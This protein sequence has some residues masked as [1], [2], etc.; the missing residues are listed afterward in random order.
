MNKLFRLLTLSCLY[1]LL[2][3][4]SLEIISSAPDDF[5]NIWKIMGILLY[6][7]I[8][9]NI[10]LL[11]VFSKISIKKQN[12]FTFIMSFLLLYFLSN[13]YFFS[14]D[15]GLM[16]YFVFHNK[17]IFDTSSLA[18][19]QDIFIAITL[20]LFTVLIFKFFNKKTIETMIIFILLV[21]MASSIKFIYLINTNKKAVIIKD[22]KTIKHKGVYDLK[23]EITFSKNSQNVLII[24]FDRFM[25]GFMP[26][27]LKDNP[28]LKQ[29]LSG[30]VW[31]PN[32]LSLGIGTA[33]GLAPIYGGYKFADAKSMMEDNF[34]WN[35]AHQIDSTNNMKQRYELST[36]FLL[37][38]FYDKGYE[39]TIFDANYLSNSQLNSM[40]NNTFKFKNIRDNKEYLEV[41]YYPYELDTK[42]NTKSPFSMTKEYMIP[43]SLF[44]VVSPTLRK[45]IYN[46]GTWLASLSS[47]AMNYSG[48]IREI[49]YARAWRHISEIKDDTDGSFNFI[50]SNLTHNVP[51][52]RNMNNTFQGIIPK[53]S[54][55]DKKRFK[56]KHTASHY[57]IALEALKQ[58]SLWFKWLKD[59]D[60]YDNTKI[61]I[62]SDHGVP[63]GF[64]PMFETQKN[65]DGIYYGSYHPLFMVK[66][67]NQSNNLEVNN[68]FMTHS[69]TAWMALMAIDKQAHKKYG[70]DK[71]KG[72]RLYTNYKDKKILRVFDDIFKAKN[73]V[74]K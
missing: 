68:S 34:K 57:H 16:D 5:K 20:A 70:Y 50:T 14:G 4:P 69:D 54:E 19:F 41:F 10:F 62:V 31:Y 35:F 36:K 28:N 45:S 11:F 18:I 6:V 22:E 60:I 1:L 72:F 64:N 24:F 32:T 33:V 66:D 29:D 2:I 26:D 12:I 63:S 17:D 13:Y 3:I 27:I 21:F 42:N 67:F 7:F 52:N 61:I 71:S 8:L 15:Y 58:A 23:K 39:A 55:L 46:N 53:Y 74:Y 51:V 9:F 40:S 49:S 56:N 44:K 65:S 48:V 43:F 25:G 37:K 73:W 38:K 30:F 47:V 59:N